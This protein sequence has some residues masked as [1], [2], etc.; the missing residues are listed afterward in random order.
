MCLQ[1]CLA[2]G[3]DFFEDSLQFRKRAMS[4]HEKTVIIP[5]CSQIANLSSACQRVIYDKLVHGA[6]Y[7][8]LNSGIYFALLNCRRILQ[9]LR[10]NNTCEKWDGGAG[11]VH[12]CNLRGTAWPQAGRKPNVF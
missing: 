10:A 3:L 8:I 6:K 9:L 4:A 12:H 2:S 5:V 7:S 11:K 1:V